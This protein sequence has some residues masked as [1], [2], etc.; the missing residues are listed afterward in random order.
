[1]NTI[2]S[3]EQLK[4]HLKTIRYRGFAFDNEED[5]IGFRHVAS[6]VLLGDGSVAAAVGVTGRIDQISSENLAYLADLVK[7][8]A[9]R[10]SQLNQPPG[11][12]LLPLMTSRRL[13]RSGI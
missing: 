13:S 4:E 12:D 6:P 3:F 9:A 7:Q 11:K 5:E 2:S 1:V 8:G 10:I